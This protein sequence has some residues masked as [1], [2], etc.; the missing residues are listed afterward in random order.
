MKR[1]SWRYRLRRV[2]GLLFVFSGASLVWMAWQRVEGWIGLWR[3][4]RY[5]RMLESL[6]GR[7]VPRERFP[8]SYY[9]RRLRAGMTVDEVDR[10]VADARDRRVVT[11]PLGRGKSAI[12]YDFPFTVSRRHELIALFDDTGL[13]RLDGNNFTFDIR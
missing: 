1:R 7:S 4:R 6:T 8:L 10:A 3:L 2:M 13:I 11:S 5:H 12:I 9:R